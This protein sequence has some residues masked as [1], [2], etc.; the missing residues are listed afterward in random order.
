MTF[1][2]IH[3][4]GLRKTPERTLG[5]RRN[6]QA[7]ADKI[8]DALRASGVQ[9][10]AQALAFQHVR[11][12]IALRVLAGPSRR[13]ADDGAERRQASRRPLRTVRV[14]NED[15]VTVPA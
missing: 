13:R 2:H 5:E 8:R 3:D 4:Q 7:T 11:L 10:A 14:A 12:D 15:A 9:A 6:D 1:L